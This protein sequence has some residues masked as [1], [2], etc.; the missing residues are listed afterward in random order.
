M[1]TRTRR[2]PGLTTA[3]PARSATLRRSGV[4]RDPRSSTGPTSRGVRSAPRFGSTTRSAGRR[5]NT[6]S[7]RLLSSAP[8]STRAAEVVAVR[9]VGV[10]VDD[11]VLRDVRVRRHLDA[12]RAQP[13]GDQRT[14]ERSRE[15]DLVAPV[16][17]DLGQRCAARHMTHPDARAAVAVDQDAHGGLLLR[18]LP[19]R[20][21]AEDRYSRVSVLQGSSI[22]VTG[23]TGSFGKAF[24]RHVARPP[25]PAPAG[26]LLP[27]R[28]QAVRGAASC[29][30][31]TSGCAGSSATCATERRLLPRACT[32]STTSCTPPRSSRSTPAEY[33]PFEFVQTNVIGSQNVIEAC[34]DAGVKQG[35]RAVDRQGV[36]PD[37]P[38]RRH[39]AD[40]RQAV[41]H[42]QPLR[43]GVR[44]PVRRGALRQRHGQPRLGH[45]VLPQAGRGRASRCRSPTCA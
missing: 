18:S 6:P 4:Q 43:R 9:Q 19:R 29:S 23:G 12:E 8:P 33:N 14:L 38:L 20:P 42:R 1:T 15:V 37:Q 10:D 35:R 45:P 5:P 26:G 32:A 16:D 21:A 30:T 22:L 2:A 44:H 25:R 39:Q 36:Q 41:H 11:V 40:R 17:G 3:C 24:I 7:S 34:I 28:A 31:T 13:V 27:R